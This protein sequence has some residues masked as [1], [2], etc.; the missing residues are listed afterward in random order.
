MPPPLQLLVYR[1]KGLYL[2]WLTEVDERNVMF[3]HSINGYMTNRVAT[4]I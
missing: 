2:G 1:Y 4:I 3:A